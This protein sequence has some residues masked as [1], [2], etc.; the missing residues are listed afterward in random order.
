MT[1]ASQAATS[2]TPRRWSRAAGALRRLAVHLAAIRYRLLIVNLIVVAVPVLGIAF[3][4]LHERQL[5]AALERDLVD[6]AA[7]VRAAI[8]AAPG[9]DRAA[10]TAALE[11][12][13][14]LT[15]ARIEL[16]DAAA[17]ASATAAAGLPATAGTRRLAGARELRRAL[18]G[19]YGAA[20]R[21]TA[22]RRR[23][24]L[25]VA[26]PRRDAAGRV[27][28][29]IRVTRST[30]P[31]MRQ[32]VALRH[33]LFDLL[34]VALAIT[35]ALSLFLAA[36]IA[37]P[38]AAVTRS[39]E[40]IA[41]GDRTVRLAL[42]RR[43]EIGKLS[44]A[45]D[46]MAGELDRRAVEQRDLAADISHELKNPL[47][48]I[49]AASELLRDGAADDPVARDR[50]LAMIVA[51]ADRLD[52]LVSRLLELARL[53]ADQDTAA[54]VDVVA[55]VTA[56]AARATAAPAAVPVEVRAPL[57]A[58]VAAR[59]DPLAAAV[60]NLI[61]NAGQ[62]ATAGTTV[63]VTVTTRADATR[64]AVHNHGPAISPALQA[65]LWRRFVTTRADRGGSGLGLAMVRA[66]ATGHG[67]TVGVASAA[68]TGTT[69]WLELRPLTGLAR[70][71]TLS[72]RSIGTG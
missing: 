5:L 51:D 48:A 16:I 52:R 68:A 39:A 54:P 61:A 6:Q 18:A 4:R 40:R 43:D 7:I 67:G 27:V 41:A 30:A 12:A 38:L 53:E 42:D 57:A 9:A 26:L 66:V 37:R 63:T 44:R 10:F 56:A 35:A 36:T 65:R 69:F 13:R 3:A 71:P 62:H 31:V 2:V 11:R 21:V 19:R 70:M 47:T 25:S 55:L 8:E 64:I 28:G 20:T 22:D 32:L 17:P 15:G 58:V 14:A 34:M 72:F 49:R 46:R 45:V 29:A 23:L 59:A 33:R 50:F 24:E 60:D 1:V